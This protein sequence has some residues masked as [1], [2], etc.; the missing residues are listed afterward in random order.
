MMQ[1]VLG[2][3]V[4]TETENL[5]SSFLNESRI[6]IDEESKELV[7]ASQIL[8]NLN[9]RYEQAKSESIQPLSDEIARLQEQLA[10]QEDFISNPVA[11]TFGEPAMKVLRDNIQTVVY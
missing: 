6:L 3:S 8:C 5:D 4:I 11:K 1:S 2:T 10:K 7:A 9:R